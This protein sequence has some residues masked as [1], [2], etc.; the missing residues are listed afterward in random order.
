MKNT[1][2]LWEHSHLE[3]GKH[4]LPPNKI[5][6]I[7][8]FISEKVILKNW[9]ELHWSL[10]KMVICFEKLSSINFK[11]IFKYKE[12]MRRTKNTHTESTLK[13]KCYWIFHH[14]LNQWNPLPNVEVGFFQGR[15]GVEHFRTTVNMSNG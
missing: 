4:L 15:A 1:Y 12:F 14:F 6:M 2:Q 11:S 5:F 7:H 8:L 3:N 13:L 9:N 10:S